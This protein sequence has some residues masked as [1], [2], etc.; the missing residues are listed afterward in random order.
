MAKAKLLPCVGGCST[1]TR[2]SFC[3]TYPRGYGF[4]QFKGVLFIGDFELL[5]DF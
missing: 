1:C 2:D 4:L 5:K 3:L